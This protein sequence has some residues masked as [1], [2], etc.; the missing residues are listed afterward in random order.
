MGLPGCSSSFFSLAVHVL[1]WLSLRGLPSLLGNSNKGVLLPSKFEHLPQVV[2]SKS[3]LSRSQRQD[4]H[5]IQSWPR[6]LTAF[7]GIPHTKACGSLTVAICIAP[8]GVWFSSTWDFPMPF[9]GG[10]GHGGGDAADD[11]GFDDDTGLP[12]RAADANHGPFA[13]PSGGPGDLESTS[14]AEGGHMA[15]HRSSP[16]KRPRTHQLNL[17]EYYELKS[18]GVEDPDLEAQLRPCLP[19]V[20]EFSETVFGVAPSKVRFSE[21]VEYYDLVP[22][23]EPAFYMNDELTMFAE[24]CLKQYMSEEHLDFNYPFRHIMDLRARQLVLLVQFAFKEFDAPHLSEEA[25]ELLLC[26]IRECGQFFSSDDR[27]LVWRW[28]ALKHQFLAGHA[29]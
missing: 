21:E 20:P 4:H 16:S 2:A 7:L 17:E 18:C 10:V 1:R 14:H 25:G 22:M 12:D 28:L 26:H 24:G 15:G 13:A 9:P 5:T 19:P 6:S 27:Q 29:A 3:F 23:A 8:A 11:D